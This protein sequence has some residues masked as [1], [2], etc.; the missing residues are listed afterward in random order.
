LNAN[1]ATGGLPSLEATAA[2]HEVSSNK[3]PIQLAGLKGVG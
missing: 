3:P 1:I 2:L